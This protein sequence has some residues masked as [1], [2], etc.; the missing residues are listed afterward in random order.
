MAAPPPSPPPDD[1][2]GLC[3]SCAWARLVTNRRGSSFTRCA[4]ADRDPRFARYPVLPVRSCE[5]Y[6]KRSTD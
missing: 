4:L 3:R 5:G 6:R 1:P 2:V